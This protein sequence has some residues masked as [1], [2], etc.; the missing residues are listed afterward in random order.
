MTRLE[1]CLLCLVGSFCVVFFLNKQQSKSRLGEAIVITTV[2]TSLQKSLLQ[3][4]G[5]K[6]VTIETSDLWLTGLRISPPKLSRKNENLPLDHT[7]FPR[8]YSMYDC[9]T[10]E[11]WVCPENTKNYAIMNQKTQ[12]IE[13]LHHSCMKVKPTQNSNDNGYERNSCISEIIQNKETR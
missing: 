4:S 9:A 10:C 5:L 12:G 8:P 1:T 2:S 6:C 3:R 13:T 7:T 11:N